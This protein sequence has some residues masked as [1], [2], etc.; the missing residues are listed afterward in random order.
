MPQPAIISAPQD[1]PAQRGVDPYAS[2]L[3]SVRDHFKTAGG[4]SHLFKTDVDPEE[5]WNLYIDSVPDRQAHTCSACHAFFR[6]YGG[7]V[8]IAKDGSTA[9][10]IW[11]GAA[12]VPGDYDTGIRRLAKGVD[13]AKVTGVFL[14]KE[15]T[16]GQPVTGEWRHFAVTLPVDHPSAWRSPVQTPGQRMAELRERFATLSRALGDFHLSVLEQAF[17]LLDSETL[18]RSEKVQGPARWLRD[19]Q[20]TLDVHREAGGRSRRNLI[21]LAVA[22]AP[23]GFCNPRSTMVG[24]L[25]EDIA[26][27]LSFDEVSRRFR[28]KMH[29]LRYQRPS[30]LP[31]ATNVAQAEKVVSRLSA[32]GAFRRRFCRL[33]EVDALWRPAATPEAP[34]NQGEGALFGGVET[35]DARG[36]GRKRNAPELEIPPV[37]MAWTRFRAEILPTATRVEIFLHDAPSSFAALVTAVDPEAPPI[38]QWD[39]ESRRNPVSWYVWHGGSRPEGFSLDSGRFHDVDAVCLSPPHW[40]GAEER[41]DHQGAAVLF[42]IRG[43][44]ETRT[45]G[46][47]AIFPECLR[48]EF[49]AVRK[50]IEA[51]SRQATLEEVEGAPAAG[52]MRSKGGQW[53]ETRVRVRAGSSSAQYLLDR[54]E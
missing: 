21:W 31:S 43:A 17:R 54:W 20:E 48:A 8:T 1:D 40:Y 22:S 45:G 44:R 11:P 51:Y 52:L 16:L 18:Y 29:P 28:A 42:L 24:T 13:G 41:F 30:S 34:K 49:R 23:P 4:K 33:D 47:A 10:A 36:K 3:A 7:L 14:A 5:L 35:R 38:L 9:S 12:D 6:R 25:L 37:K 19:L 27:G 32:A 26:D 53:N 46:G 2:L 15:D 50:T 39:S